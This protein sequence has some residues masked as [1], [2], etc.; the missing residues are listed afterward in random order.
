[1]TDGMV[2]GEGAAA[3]AATPETGSA[4]P[5]D[6]RSRVEGF[7][8]AGDDADSGEF[9]DPE[10]AAAG[11]LVDDGQAIGEDFTDD[12]TAPADLFGMPREEFMTAM[13][14][15]E[16]G[17]L[18]ESMYDAMKIKITR[19]GA[20]EFV[21]LSEWRDGGLRQNDYSRKLNTL[22]EER[23]AFSG[24]RD[25]FSGMVDGWKKNPGGM[26]DD[27]ELLGI[28]I[29]AVLEPVAR[30]YAQ[31]AD[32]SPRERSLAKRV[33]EAERR[34]RMSK[35][36]AR[37]EQAALDQSRESVEQG[38]LRE[39]VESVRM[40]AFVNAKVH[41]GPVAR[42][43]F[44]EH[45]R[46][47]WQDGPLTPKLAQDAAQATREDLIQ[48]AKNYAANAPPPGGNPPLSAVQDP[49][50]AAPRPPPARGAAPR[51]GGSQGTREG[52][53]PSDFREHIEA[54]RERRAR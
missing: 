5:E 16:D 19:D 51:G 42:R 50:G 9:V 30:M 4:A 23:Q 10:L 26:A 38:K 33:R 6:F 47:F 27:L 22:R 44:H 24:T 14:G 37:T 21:P 43:I 32:L 40:P 29:E 12:E 1:M 31:E 41:D 45:L 52:G 49:A 36:R 53:S 35:L 7:S 34:E 46:T 25:A 54:L 28:D 17:V 18:P 8:N 15:A 48:M 39:R 11:A 13:E 2:S 3:P 20:D